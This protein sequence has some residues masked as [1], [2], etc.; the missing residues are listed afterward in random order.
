M[1]TTNLTILARELPNFDTIEAFNEV[2]SMKKNPSMITS[3]N[4]FEDLLKDIE[5]ECKE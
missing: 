5:S 4:N 2:E 1:L 3:Y